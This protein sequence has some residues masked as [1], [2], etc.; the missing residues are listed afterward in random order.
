MAKSLTVYS[1]PRVWERAI[2]SE[3]IPPCGNKYP[4]GWL[5]LKILETGN[6]KLETRNWKLNKISL[7]GY[8]KPD[9]FFGPLGGSIGPPQILIENWPP[10]G[11]N[12]GGI[13]QSLKSSLDQDL[14]VKYGRFH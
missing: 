9:F 2:K 10:E 13:F 12:F 8:W 3:T 5:A 14:W 6:W 4:I 11:A 7:V 1:P